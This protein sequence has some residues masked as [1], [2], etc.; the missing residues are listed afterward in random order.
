VFPALKD[1]PHTSGHQKKKV[2]KLF[3]VCV[4]ISELTASKVFQKFSFSHSLFLH[5]AS[6]GLS[7][8]CLCYSSFLGTFAKLQKVTIGFVMSVCLSSAWHNLPPTGQSF[9]KFEYFSKICQK[10]KFH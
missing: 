10:F 5:S 8:S 9:M 1:L 7:Q 2:P 4:Y 3:E 6:S